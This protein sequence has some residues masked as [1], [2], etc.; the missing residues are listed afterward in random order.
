[1]SDLLITPAELA[2][3]IA[4]QETLVL[5][6]RHD[7]FDHAAG[8]AAYVSGH[9]PGAVFLDHEA[10]LSGQQTGSNGRHP[11]PERATFGALM[12]SIGLTA[13]SKVVVYDAGNSTF[14]SHVW[15]M[16]HWIGHSNVKVLDGGWH[17]WMTA[18]GQ[19]ETGTGSAQLAVASV[20]ALP[21]ATM[22]N[23]DA[24][25]VLANLNNH[26]FTIVDA[27]DATRFR[28]EAEPIDPVA[29]H[30]PGALNRFN[31][32]NLQDDGRFK[33]AHQLLEEFTELL[34]GVAPQ[35]VVHQCGSG[36]TACHNL[37]AMELAGLSGSGLY[38]GS[39]SEWCSDTNRPVA[40][41]SSS[42]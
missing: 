21:Q 9:I 20:A 4:A 37:F 36:I 32:L 8:R 18:Q 25:A 31:G 42:A 29:G 26:K 24:S 11:L 6:V 13:A 3:L 19:V 35:D 7:L 38:P 39:W 22:P 33:P 10:Q 41:G 15:W 40:T 34:Q 16:L 14:A 30:I 17:A 27:R 28:G 2:S 12:Q 1:M 5:D 23:V